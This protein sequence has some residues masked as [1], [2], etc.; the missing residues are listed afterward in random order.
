MGYWVRVS[1]GLGLDSDF[2]IGIAF[3][4]IANFRNQNSELEPDY[5]D[6]NHSS[7]DFEMNYR[8]TGL[9]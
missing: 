1:E 4:G 9:Q 6:G 7:V 5:A 2:V 8:A 3:I